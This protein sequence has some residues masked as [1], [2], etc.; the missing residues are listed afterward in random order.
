MWRL[1][2]AEYAGREHGVPLCIELLRG[3]RSSAAGDGAGEYQTL[4]LSRDEAAFVGM[5][6]L[7]VND[8]RE[9]PHPMLLRCVLA[10]PNGRE[11]FVDAVLTHLLFRY[12]KKKYARVMCCSCVVCVFYS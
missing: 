5:R 10:L 3:V 6:S 4:V 9:S 12:K 8:E 2:A 1:L 7:I 11:S